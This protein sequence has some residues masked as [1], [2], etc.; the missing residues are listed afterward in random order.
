MHWGDS[1]A[2]FLIKRPIYPQFLWSELIIRVTT[3]CAVQIY[4]KS[5][6]SQFFCYHQHL[7]YLINYVVR[8]MLASSISGFVIFL[9]PIHARLEASGVDATYSLI[10]SFQ[11]LMRRHACSVYIL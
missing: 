10:F 1:L 6:Q 11:H 9:I 7:N 4:F 3:L 2:F 5:D 8:M